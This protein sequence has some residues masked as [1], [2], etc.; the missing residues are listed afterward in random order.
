[1]HVFLAII[2]GIPI[3]FQLSATGA[4]GALLAVPLLIYVAGSSVEEAVTISLVIVAASSLIGMWEYGRAGHI[5]SRVV[6]AFSGTGMIGAWMGAY[7]HHL[8][9]AE[10]LLILFGV[11]LLITRALMMRHA[12]Q[13]NVATTTDDCAVQFPK[14]CWIKAAGLGLIVGCVNGVFGVGGGFMIVPALV[15]LMKFPS[16]KAIGT[17]LSIIS[18]NAF[19]AIAGHLQFGT[20][21]IRLAALVFVGSVIGVLLGARADRLMSPRTMSHVTASVTISLALWLIVFN[22]MRLLGVGS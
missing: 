19:A 6:P 17:S 15:L 20:L 2:S 1:M 13:G 18:L 9:P 8:M 3:G 21:N 11:L 4:G 7:V 22:S 10:V 14:T 16:R 12:A 5:K